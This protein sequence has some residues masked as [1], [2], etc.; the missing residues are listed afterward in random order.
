MSTPTPRKRDGRVRTVRQEQLQRAV[1]EGRLAPD[2]AQAMND[3]A[4]SR[5]RASLGFAVVDDI[6]RLAGPASGTIRVPEALVREAVPP[7]VDLSNAGAVWEL[8]RAVLA[9]GTAEQQY[10]L[11]NAGLLERLWGTGLAEGP[12][13]GVWESRFPRLAR[14]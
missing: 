1:A 9:D 10:A 7:E 13:M 5:W 2:I 11:L 6:D 4:L 12:V 14:G 8:Y 3:P